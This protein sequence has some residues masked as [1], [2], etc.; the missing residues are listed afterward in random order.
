LSKIFRQTRQ[1]RRQKYS[2]IAHQ[3]LQQE[4]TKQTP[5]KIR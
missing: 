3:K 1:Y 4:K 2:H 5:S